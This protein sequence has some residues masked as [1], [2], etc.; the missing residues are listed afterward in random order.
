MG[1]RF[2]VRLRFIYRQVPTNEAFP[3]NSYSC[4]LCTVRKF[5]SGNT[6]RDF[7]FPHVL[8]TDCYA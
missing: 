6:R 5:F 4:S 2:S 3:A 1:I 7:I 8:L